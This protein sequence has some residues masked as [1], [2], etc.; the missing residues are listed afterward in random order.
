MIA[1]GQP[2]K[3]TEPRTITIRRV[4]EEY[5]RET[6]TSEDTYADNVKLWYH[7]LVPHPNRRVLKFHE[8]GDT[9]ADLEANGQLLG[10]CLRKNAVRF[11]ADLEE[12]VV[13]A[14][15]ERY[16]FPLVRELSAR[17]GLLAVPIP[18]S[19]NTKHTATQLQKL[20][21]G[22]GK[23]IEALAPVVADGVVDDKD[24]K[25]ARAAL[26]KLEQLLAEVEYWRQACQGVVLE[27][28]ED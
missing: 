25:A 27:H 21:D 26:P 19:G 9:G 17:Y 10:R 4:V 6:S 22:F 20:M 1:T 2:T 16:R 11:P 28:E 14:L 5:L 7:K 12:A 13:M 24:L 8:T 15:P 18:E 3:Y 23:S